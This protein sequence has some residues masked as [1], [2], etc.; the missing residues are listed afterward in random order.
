MNYFKNLELN[1]NNIE[2]IEEFIFPFEFYEIDEIYYIKLITGE[3]L[4]SVFET[5][6]DEGF[7]GNGYDWESLVI[8]FANE[9]C[10][11]KVLNE[12]EFDSEADMFCMFSKNKELIEK[13]IIY[14]KYICNNNE[15]ILTLFNKAELN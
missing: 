4:Q 11:D 9:Y 12:I 7:E 15:K 14:F 2:N 6:E 10:Y 5:R 3:Y 13:F 1:I 8:A